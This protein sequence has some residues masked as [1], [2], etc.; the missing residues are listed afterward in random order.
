MLSQQ[1]RTSVTSVGSLLDSIDAVGNWRAVVL[2]L[3]TLVLAALVMA[4]GGALVQVS[5]VLT[6]LFSLLALTVAF[7]GANAVGMMMM[8]EARGFPSRPIV[9]AAM[10]SLATSHRLILVL[11]IVAATYLLGTLAFA[12]LLFVCKVPG[13]GPLLY[14]FVFPMG[15][16][17]SGVAIFAVP[18]VIVPLSAPAIWSGAGTTA[19]VSQLLAVSRKRLLLVLL[20]MIAVSAIAAVVGWLIAA[21][22][23]SG[24]WFTGLLS[25]AVLGLSEV[26]GLSGMAASSMGGLIGGE[27]GGGLDGYATAAIVGGGLLFAAAFPLP[28]MV[29]LRGASSVYLRAIEGLDMRAE[30]AALNERIAAAKAKAREMHAHAQATA[31][32]YAQQ[33][34]TYVPAATEA[35]AQSGAVAPIAAIRVATPGCPACGTALE[36]GDTFC[37]GC[38]RKLA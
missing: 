13:I 10:S 7:Y 11:L 38:G 15:I 29:Y 12:L 8:D 23:F 6:L 32:Q 37:A 35:S 14:T 16:V 31:Q 33:A 36:P 28:F 30:Q 25:A 21:V 22:L 5:G 17:I 19:C 3:G 34:K 9:A 2:L 24:F 18:T 20:L 27:F 26:G 4:L 1:I